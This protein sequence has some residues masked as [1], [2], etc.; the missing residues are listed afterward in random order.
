VERKKKKRKKKK[1]CATHAGGRGG[2]TPV[3]CKQET[4]FDTKETKNPFTE[5]SPEKKG[6]ALIRGALSPNK[7]NSGER[8]REMRSL[9]WAGDGEGEK[10]RRLGS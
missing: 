3:D 6:K 1:K 4:S 2:A 8:N 9:W 7:E 5:D 10:A